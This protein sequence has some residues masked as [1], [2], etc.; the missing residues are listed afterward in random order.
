M[1]FYQAVFMNETIGFFTSERKAIETIIAA[2]RRCWE[3]DWTGEA[4]EEWIKEFREERYDDF[5]GTWV[6]EENLNTEPYEESEVDLKNF[7]MR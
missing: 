7:D 1:K 6:S 4:L 3:N 5:N 2:A